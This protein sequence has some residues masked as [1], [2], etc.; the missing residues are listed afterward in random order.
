MTS[1]LQPQVDNAVSPSEVGHTECEEQVKEAESCMQSCREMFG[2]LEELLEV[3]PEYTK[4]EIHTNLVELITK[5]RDCARVQNIA[6]CRLEVAAPLYL[7][8]KMI[9]PVM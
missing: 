1:R 5:I 2:Q 6:E 3:S 9:I 8:F 4:V 7:I